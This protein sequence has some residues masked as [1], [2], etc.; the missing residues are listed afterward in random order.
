LVTFF[1]ARQKKSDLPGGGLHPNQAKKPFDGVDPPS[2]P[3]GGENARCPEG[4]KITSTEST[5]PLDPRF[6][7]GDAERAVRRKTL[8]GGRKRPAKQP[9]RRRKNPFDEVDP[10][11][12]PPEAKM[13]AVRAADCRPYTPITNAVQNTVTPAGRRKKPPSTESTLHN[14][15][16]EA[17]NPLRRSRLSL[18]VRRIF[19]RRLPCVVH[20]EINKKE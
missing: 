5:A 4:N 9:R 19:H 1:L 16:P 6:R 15:P 14:P 18:R 11:T 12:T 7:G 3:A 10:H 20:N 17:K 8:P 2:T 13:H